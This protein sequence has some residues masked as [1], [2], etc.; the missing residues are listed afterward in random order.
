MTTIGK[1]E[2]FDDTKE[3][4]ETYVERVEQFFLAN[5]IDDDHKVPTLLSLIGGKTY[6]LLR[7]LLAP[8]KPATKS[9]Q[10]IVTTLQ[11]HL[12]PKPLEIAERFRFYKKNQQEGESIL[13]YVA[14]LR[15]LAT[16][17]NFGGNLNEALRDRLVCGLRN[18]QIQKRLL[19]EAKLKY[20]KA[21]EIAVAM[22]TAIRDA[23]ELQSE[24]YSRWQVDWTQQTNTSETGDHPPLLPL[25]WE[26][27]FDTQLFLQGPEN[28]A[29]SSEFVVQNSKAS[30]SKQ[31]KPQRYMLL[32]LMLM[33][34]RMKTY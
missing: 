13:S 20:S 16:H 2:S 5:D 33:L 4:W 21:V 29:I 3:N 25:W 32:R 19:S 22:E 17:C 27:A 26:H 8:E 34:M 12:S 31:P 15:K 9:F 11:E 30:L 7:D 1:I 10:Q 23:S 24:L 18:M 6:T 28:R 14:E